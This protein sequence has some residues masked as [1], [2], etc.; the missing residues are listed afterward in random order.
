MVDKSCASYLYQK[1]GVYY[2]SK[3]VPCDVRQHYKRDRIVICLKTKS[4]SRANRMCDSILDSATPSIWIKAHPWRPLKTQN[5]QKC[6]PAVGSTL[7]G[8]CRAYESSQ[9][10]FLFPRYCSAGGNK[11]DY[12]SNGLNKWL[13]PMV[14]QGCVV[15]SF[16][17]SFRDRLRAV[18]CPSDI[19][20]QL[21]GWK[22]VGVGQGYGEGYPLEVLAKWTSRIQLQF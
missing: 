22:T 14:P 10:K 1:R 20:D 17:H 11:S 19:I 16:R 7:W 13:R 21:G 4:V 9:C 3:Q 6:I 15:H 5:S 8:L 18:H 12:A 2:F